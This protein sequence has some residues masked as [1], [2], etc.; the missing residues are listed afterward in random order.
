MRVS[1]IIPMYNAEDY[2]DFC[3]KSL[4]EQTYKDLEIIMVD[5]GSIDRTYEICNEYKEK[6]RNIKIIK[7]ENGGAADARNIG[8]ANATGDYYTF[9]D[10]DDFI[11]KNYIE[12]I[13]K[14]I[15]KEKC[16]IVITNL[17][18]VQR[19]NIKKIYN[20]KIKKYIFSSEQ[21]IE[22]VMYQKKFDSAVI[23]KFFNKRCFEE[24]KFPKGN[25]YED[26]AIIC[27]LFDMANKIVFTNVNGYYYFIREESITHSKFVSQKMQLIGVCEANQK[28]I[29]EKYPRLEKA[30]IARKTN[31][32]LHLYLQIS[33]DEKYKYNKEENKIWNIIKEN[34][35]NVLVNRKVRL[36]TKLALIFSIFGKG[37]LKQKFIKLKKFEK[38]T[39]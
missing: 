18:K 32:A 19:R 31:S 30:A 37:L 1:I 10:S 27:N 2:I 29:A 7:K 12:R 15:E 16:D 6:N 24:I 4:L 36:K 39:I 34:R 35:K 25:I 22:A 20:K 21:A 3:I 14:I 23:G 5:D 9:V 8:I 38:K 28:F 13:V 33:N 26:I 11:D 17:Q